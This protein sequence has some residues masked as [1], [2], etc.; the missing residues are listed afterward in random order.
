MSLGAAEHVPPPQAP[1]YEFEA[2]VEAPRHHRYWRWRRL[3]FW[4][5]LAIAAA[6]IAWLLLA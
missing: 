3:A 6:L 1:G 5:V 4:L 2:R